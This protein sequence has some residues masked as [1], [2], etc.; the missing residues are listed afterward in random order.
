MLKKRT[1][2][3]H[4]SDA[5]GVFN[6]GLGLKEGEFTLYTEVL[7]LNCMKVIEVWQGHLG[8]GY[9]FKKEINKMD[10]LI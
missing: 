9:G 7:N 3:I 2:H 8:E 4:L 6:E 1:K 10:I 5:K